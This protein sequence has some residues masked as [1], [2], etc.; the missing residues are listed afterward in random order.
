MSNFLERISF[1]GMRDR[2]A[3]SLFHRKCLGVYSVTLLQSD[4][5]LATKSVR[6]PSDRDFVRRIAESPGRLFDAFQAPSC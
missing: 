1:G 3:R 4:V 5:S 2:P 6:L